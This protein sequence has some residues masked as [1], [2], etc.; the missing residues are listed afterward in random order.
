MT[1]AF[2]SGTRRDLVVNGVTI[3]WSQVSHEAQ[4]HP[5]A[6]GQ[7]AKAWTA[8]AR[9]L[10]VRELLLQKA[11]ELLLVPEPIEIKSGQFET[12]DEA[13]IRQVLDHSLSPIKTPEDKLYALYKAHPERFRSPPLWDVSHILIAPSSLDN[14]GKA[15]AFETAQNLIETL[16]RNPQQ[17]EHLAST[18]SA[19]SSKEARGHLGQ[20]GPGETAPEFEQALRDL[21]EG[22]ITFNP[23]QTKFGTHIIRLNAV[24]HGQ[25]LPF[26]RVLPRLQEAADKAEWVRSAHRF[27]HDLITQAEISG[28]DGLVSFHAPASP[29][30]RSV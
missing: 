5:S 11:K 17:F 16:K 8:A 27:T 9:A 30:M 23:V 4:N 14:D 26:D 1:V 12:D 3:P 21:Q 13:L 28:F 19:C 6:K 18:L 15:L 24:A 20:I 29:D 25:V 22:E 7:W 2:N 10:I